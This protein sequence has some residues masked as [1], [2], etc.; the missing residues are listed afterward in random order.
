MKNKAEIIAIVKPIVR[1]AVEK[2]SNGEDCYQ[3]ALDI[4]EEQDK[5]PNE[6]NNISLEDQARQYAITPKSPQ[7]SIL[8]IHKITAF[9]AGAQW[10]KDQIKHT[11]EIAKNALFAIHLRGD[12]IGQLLSGYTNEELSLLM[13]NAYNKLYLP[14]LVKDGSK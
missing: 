6:V 4:L 7:G 10:Q 9:E 14:H 2:W 8:F 5:Q 11:L 12:N 13:E 3:Q 1:E